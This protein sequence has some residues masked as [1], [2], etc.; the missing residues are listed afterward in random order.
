MTDWYSR[1][2]EDDG[3]TDD[4]I[5]SE[6][7]YDRDCDDDFPIDP[8]HVAE[9]QSLIDGEI[10]GWAAETGIEHPPTYVI[11]D[12]RTNRLVEVTESEMRRHLGVGE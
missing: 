9:A 3:R 5:M 6:I 4:E 11:R 2:R 1:A 8:H 7:M 12:E 10:P